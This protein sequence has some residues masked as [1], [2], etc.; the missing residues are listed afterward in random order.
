MYSDNGCRVC[1]DCVTGSG[2]RNKAWGVCGGPSPYTY[3]PEEACLN[4]GPALCEVCADYIPEWA[5]TQDEDPELN[6]SFC[7]NS[8]DDA[9]LFLSGK[10]E[11]DLITCCNAAQAKEEIDPMSGGCDYELVSATKSCLYNSMI[12]CMGIYTPPNGWPLPT[13]YPPEP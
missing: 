8:K 10:I 1:T 2:A 13:P 9:W 4:P 7:E 5:W 6:T 12:D 3:N 11:S